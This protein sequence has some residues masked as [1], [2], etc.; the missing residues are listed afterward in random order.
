MKATSQILSACALALGLLGTATSGSVEAAR[1]SDGRVLFDRPPTLVEATTFDQQA[2]FSSRYHFVVQVPE[3]AGEPLEAIAITPRDSAQRIQFKHDG[4]TAQQGTAYAH[5]PVL[6]LASVGG[7]AANPE[8]ILIVFDQPVQPGE[9]VT[10]TLPTAR[11]PWGGV[12]LFGVTAY[13]SGGNGVGQ[14]LGYGRINIYD[15]DK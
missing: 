11:N 15:S 14:F 6:P 10:V 1:L 5:G 3:D 8:D 2:G 12:Y 9:T 13:P 7:A 4:V